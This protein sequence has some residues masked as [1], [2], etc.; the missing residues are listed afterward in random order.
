MNI[1]EKIKRSWWVILSFIMFLN[2]FGFIYIA[3]KHNNKNWLM[4]GAMYE[5]PW[6]IYFI[7][8]VK[9][10]NPNL[11]FFS[12]S[13]LILL[14]AFMLLIISIIRSFWVAIKLADVYDNEEK[15]T[16][17][18][19]EL[20]K[21]KVSDE[22]KGINGKLACCLCLFVIFILFVVVAL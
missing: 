9:F 10:G 6:L 18:S 13:S 1:A 12:P 19:T 14:I 5:L 3:L 11:D 8:F 22:N 15:Y 21:P 2:G 4:E 16:I 17:Q 7:F 20:T